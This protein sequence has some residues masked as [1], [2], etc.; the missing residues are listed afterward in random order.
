MSLGRRGS[1]KNMLLG[2]GFGGFSVCLVLGWVFLVG[3]FF[4]WG[5]GVLGFFFFD[6]FSSVSLSVFNWQLIN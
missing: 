4:C 6:L 3:W 2:L 1:G 5:F